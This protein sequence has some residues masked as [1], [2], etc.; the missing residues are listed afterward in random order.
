M[1]YASTFI[2]EKLNDTNYA[3]WSEEIFVFLQTKRAGRIILGT[4]TRPVD[5]SLPEKPMSI[6]YQKQL[7]V[8]KRQTDWD[9]R[10]EAA[11][12]YL[13]LSIENS[14]RHHITDITDPKLVW[15]KLKEVHVKPEHNA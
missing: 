15:E 12:G 11:M 10:K 5:H 2:S 9:E 7:E 3:I 4:G 13:R 6:D 8:E 14:Q 1:S